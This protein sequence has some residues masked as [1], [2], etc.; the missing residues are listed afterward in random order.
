MWRISIIAFLALTLMGVYS[1]KPIHIDYDTSADFKQYKTYNYYPNLK[2]GLSDLND[3]RMK[4]AV[5][6]V[7]R[8]KGFVKSNTPD[9]LI[10]YYTKQTIKPSYSSV[11]LG[12]GQRIGRRGGI[13]IN[14]RIPINTN[15]KIQQITFDIIDDKKD[16][17]IWQAEMS[18]NV[19][20]DGTIT[21]RDAQYL[22]N[23]SKLLKN[24]P[25]E[26]K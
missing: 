4:R 10:N 7:M 14:T 18:A 17:L 13:G 23:V 8:S 22:K 24:F 9:V 2:S 25:P 19:K 1:C 6:N 11:D 16:K 21:S 12:I 20:E 26:Y 3:S 15:K 5:D